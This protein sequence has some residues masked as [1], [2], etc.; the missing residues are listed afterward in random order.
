MGGLVQGKSHL[1]MD[2]L[3]VPSFMEIPISKFYSCAARTESGS[4]R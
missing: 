2:D 4:A 3:G 1:E